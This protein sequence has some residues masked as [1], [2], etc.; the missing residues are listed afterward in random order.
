MEVNWPKEA[1]LAILEGI[2]LDQ[3]E[4]KIPAAVRASILMGDQLRLK[5]EALTQLLAHFYEVKLHTR[6]I[7]TSMAKH[8]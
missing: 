1:D 6:S 5:Q 3:L 2:R 8:C 7:T 4:I